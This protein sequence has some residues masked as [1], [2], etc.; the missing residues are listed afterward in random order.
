MELQ[1][2]FANHMLPVGY[3]LDPEYSKHDVMADM[4][5]QQGFVRTAQKLLPDVDLTTLTV[6]LMK[7]R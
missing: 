2:S 5:V 7:F 6:D 4:E 1:H 3:V